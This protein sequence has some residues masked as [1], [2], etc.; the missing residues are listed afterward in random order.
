[1]KIVAFAGSPRKEGNTKNLINQFV[2]FAKPL[3][4]E[5]EV[6]DVV[7]AKPLPCTGCMGCLKK[8]DKKCVMTGDSMNEWIEK[9]SQADGVIIASPTYFANVT[10]E[11]KCII[12]RFGI[13]ARVNKFMWK[14]KPAAAIVAVRRAGAVPTFDAIN[15]CFQINQMLCVGS[16]YWNLGQ[17]LRPGDVEADAEATENMKALAEDFAWLIQKIKG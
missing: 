17:G 11:I 13:V 9:V 7:K 4:I 6:I 5:T 10:P 15:R 1:M 12:D 16:T 3:G 8:K 14:H 2:E